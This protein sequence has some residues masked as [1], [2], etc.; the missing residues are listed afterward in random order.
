ME[1]LLSIQA[2]MWKVSRL[3]QEIPPSRI[4][5]PKI[6]LPGLFQWGR[7]YRPVQHCRLDRWNPMCRILLLLGMCQVGVWTEV[8]KC[9]LHR[10]SRSWILYSLFFDRGV[11]LVQD[12]W[13][14]PQGFC[15]KEML[16]S[17]PA[18]PC[19]NKI[20]MLVMLERCLDSTIIEDRSHRRSKH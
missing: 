6:E 17:V 10:V 8:P 14:S 4:V 18:I 5:D 7:G 16:Y 15:E 9:L 11:W 1:Q 20:E 13:K 19:I 2:T 12:L 3:L